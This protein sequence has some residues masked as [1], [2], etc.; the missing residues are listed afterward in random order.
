[1][2]MKQLLSIILFASVLLT[3][4]RKEQPSMPNG[5]TDCGCAEETSADFFMEEMTE[6]NINFARYTDTDTIYANK[7]VRFT[8]KVE[9]AEYTWYIGA[10]VLT[11]STVNRF[12]S[13]ALIGQTLPITLVV[14]KN[15]NSICFPNDDGYDS[16]TKYLTIVE[17]NIYNNNTISRLEG[18]YKMKSPLL[19][20]STIITVEIYY[21]NGS[22]QFLKIYNYDGQESNC[23]IGSSNV[24]NNYRQLWT[25]GGTG[26][27]QGDYLQG[28]LIDR[29]DGLAEM[30]FTTGEYVNGAYNTTF[31]KWEY[32]GRKL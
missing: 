13:T 14:R 23:S 24:E 29:M 9:G 16:I 6:A 31:Y 19:S 10:D 30:N 32:K 21:Q 5:L 22:N 27:M 12:F 28:N 20:D 2:M 25:F 7:N 26:T 1:M 3:S 18:L 17:R 15:P 8:A 11:T 4:C